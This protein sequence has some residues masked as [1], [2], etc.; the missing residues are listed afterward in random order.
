MVRKAG[1]FALAAENAGVRIMDHGP[2]GFSVRADVVSVGDGLGRADF[3]A[4][5]APDAFVGVELGLAPKVRVRHMGLKGEF[6]RIRA[7][8][9]GLHRF[10][11]FSDFG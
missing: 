8:N 2:H 1:R 11:D 6:R 10:N 4:R 7:F 3:L 5:G 9:N